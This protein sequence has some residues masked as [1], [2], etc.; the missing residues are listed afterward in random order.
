MMSLFPPPYPF[1]IHWRQFKMRHLSDDKLVEAYNQ[2][3]KSKLDNDFLQ[4]LRKELE[5]TFYQHIRNY[6]TKNKQG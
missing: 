1:A 5:P 3:K 6:E 2:R 4:Q